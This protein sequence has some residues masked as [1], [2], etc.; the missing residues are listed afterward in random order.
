MCQM[1]E[2][3]EAELRRMGIAMNEK[4]TVELDSGTMEAVRRDATAHGHDVAKEVREIV[5][6]KFSRIGRGD[7]DYA[8]EFRRIRA[9]TPKG[10]E[11]T[12]SWKI[13]RDSR[14]HDH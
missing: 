13:I 2:E 4:I 9:M 3:Y 1:C 6:E 12:P 14:D 8:A 5:R 10:V 7:I 11:Q